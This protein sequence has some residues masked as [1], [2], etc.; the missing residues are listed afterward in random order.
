MKNNKLA[1]FIIVMVLVLVGCID[2]RC[3]VLKDKKTEH[4]SI[5]AEAMKEIGLDKLIYIRINSEGIIKISSVESAIEINQDDFETEFLSIPK[6]EKKGILIE[7]D[8]KTPF[9]QIYP[10]IKVIQ[11][12][13]LIKNTG[14]DIRGE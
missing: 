7:V 3:V 6:A 4:V 12:K 11:E 8:S 13:N 5:L 14:F 9:F 2:K 10:I 1:L